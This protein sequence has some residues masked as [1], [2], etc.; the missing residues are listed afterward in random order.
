MFE[1]KKWYIRR[2][3]V[4][5]EVFYMGFGAC[6]HNPKILYGNH[7]HTSVVE[8]AYRC[9]DGWILQTHNSLYAVLDDQITDD[10]EKAEESGLLLKELDTGFSPGVIPDDD[11]SGTE[12][13][14]LLAPIL[15]RKVHKRRREV[16]QCGID[17]VVVMEFNSRA[18]YHIVSVRSVWNRRYAEGTVYVHSGM[19]QDSVLLGSGSYGY[20]YDFRFFSLGHANTS[21]YAWDDSYNVILRNVGSKPMI[22]EVPEMGELVVPEG[23]EI[24]VP[25]KQKE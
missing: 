1:L 12:G 13:G 4:K 14:V 20:H 19:F 6:H 3:D 7:I 24:M 18:T 15:K 10:T 9:E 17:P 25:M 11:L 5:D 21:F 2:F 23:E 8:A 22:F 16:L